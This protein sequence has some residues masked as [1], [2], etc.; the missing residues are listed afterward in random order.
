MAWLGPLL[1]LIGGGLGVAESA[2][3]SGVAQQAAQLQNNIAAAQEALNQQS[4]QQKL[5]VM[6]QLFPFFAQYLQQGSPFLS[7]IQGGA[8]NQNA[9]QFGNAAGQL[10]GEMQTSGLGYGPSGTTA[11]AL[12]QLGQGAAQNSIQNYLQNLLANEQ[13]KFQAAQGIQGL[14]NM[15]NFG[16]QNMPTTQ[17]VQTTTG[18]SVGALGQTLGNMI[19]QPSQPQGP[20]YPGAPPVT[21]SSGGTL[22]PGTFG[23][24]PV[25]GGVPNA[26]GFNLG[27][28]FG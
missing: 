27:T 8:A 14:G 7:Q 4:Q 10:R 1:G 28:N 25:P 17:P 13:V 11:S 3:N 12:G 2:Q 5:Q 20:Q 9:Q 21:N 22:P 24:S 23:P 19:G 16:G 26:S 6:Q 18:S 15:F